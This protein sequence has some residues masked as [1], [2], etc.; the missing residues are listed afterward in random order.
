MPFNTE[1]IDELNNT[2]IS[3]TFSDLDDIL[4]DMYK[5]P[6]V[7]SNL[8]SEYAYNYCQQCG[9]CC[10]ACKFFCY[11]QDC[12]RFDRDICC[13]F[14]LNTELSKMDNMKKHLLQL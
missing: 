13:S 7:I 5:C 6:K 1:L 10:N 14:E 3:S 9:E 11:I 2:Q 8:I 4:S 12:P